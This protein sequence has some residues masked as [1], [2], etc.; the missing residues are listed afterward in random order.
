MAP[1]SCRRLGPAIPDETLFGGLD[2]AATLAAGTAVRTRGLVGEAASIVVLP[3]AERAG[4][5]LAAR[6]ARLIEAGHCVVALDEG[7]EPEKALPE[8]LAERLAAHV[9]LDG[10]ALAECDA[11]GADRSRRARVSGRCERTTRR[12]PR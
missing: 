8:A 9:G 7:A 2:L 4:S 12:W 5:A 6:M 10:L 3:M 1:R 11:E